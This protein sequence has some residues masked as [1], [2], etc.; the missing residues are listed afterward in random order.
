MTAS[1]MAFVF[2]PPSHRPWRFTELAQANID[3]VGIDPDL[4]LTQLVAGDF[5]NEQ[6]LTSCLRG[7]DSDRVE[8]WFDYVQE[9]ASV[10]QDVISAGVI[11]AAK[12]GV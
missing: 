10:A 2:T 11:E 8:G 6:L 9:V 7:A 4:D 1:N 5:T 3:E 12:V